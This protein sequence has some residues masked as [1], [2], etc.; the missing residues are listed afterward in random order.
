MGGEIGM[1]SIVG[2]GSTFW[3][4]L[5]RALRQTTPLH[6]AS[7]RDPVFTEEI[8]SKVLYVEDNAANLRLVERVLSRYPSFLLIAAMTG[9]TGLEL[10]KA[11][12][13]DV[14]LLDIHLP[15]IDGY[16]VLQRLRQD[17]LTAAIPVIAVSADAMPL[18]IE[19]G[20]KAGFRHY[21]T[22]PIN[23]G[24]LIEVITAILPYS[25]LKAPTRH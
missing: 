16:E 25:D 8:R 15:G 4:D 24:E 18:D 1:T 21:L 20:L 6:P 2:E 5:P 22:K 7:S 12:H 23:I 9:E 10:A 17:P 13:P 3:F 14:I 11:H 19:R